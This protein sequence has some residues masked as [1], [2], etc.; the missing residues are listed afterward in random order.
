[1]TKKLK[2]QFKKT[3]IDTAFPLDSVS[4]SSAVTSNGIGPNISKLKIIFLN[5]N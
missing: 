2:N 4:N 3:A 1:M 5:K